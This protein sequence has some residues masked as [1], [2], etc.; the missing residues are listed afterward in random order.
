MFAA[1]LLA[2]APAVSAPSPT[3]Q[4][5]P[6]PGWTQLD[7]GANTRFFFPRIDDSATF[8][9][10]FPTQSLDGTLAQTLSASWHRA[11]G[12]ERLVDAQQ[13]SV[14]VSDG[15]PALLEIVAT[16]DANNRGIYR[17]FVVKQYGERVVSGELRSND[18]Q[19]MKSVGDDALRILESMS[20][21]KR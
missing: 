11:I 13:K 19:K 15:A 6:L 5:R 17:V 14:P 20:V 8:V 12:R 2:V 7:D 18:P 1:L 16:V 4:I 10:I 3:T 21:T 9:A